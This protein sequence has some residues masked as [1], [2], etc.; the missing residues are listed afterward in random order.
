MYTEGL[1]AY[2]RVSRNPLNKAE[3][4]KTLVPGPNVEKCMQEAA[5]TPGESTVRDTLARLSVIC[6]GG[7]K[8]A[9][10][11]SRGLTMSAT[12]PS[13]IP[14]SLIYGTPDKIRRSYR[15]SECPKS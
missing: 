3:G 1:L 6:R 15:A 4:G 13:L 12:H 8:I 11:S 14:L 7:T 2:K 5:M 9:L 10:L